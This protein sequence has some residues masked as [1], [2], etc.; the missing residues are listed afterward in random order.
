MSMSTSSSPRSIRS[1]RASSPTP[2]GG[3]YEL[4]SGVEEEKGDIGAATD[5]PPI[6]PLDGNDFLDGI[7]DGGGG[8]HEFRIGSD[9][10]A[11]GSDDFDIVPSES[12]VVD[13]IASADVEKS[14]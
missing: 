9:D 4:W 13:D 12:F 2:R 7:G 1:T 5:I 14:D 8:D 11:F 6:E 3:D 10:F